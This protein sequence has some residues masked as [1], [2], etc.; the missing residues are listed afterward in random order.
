MRSHCIETV[1]ES[2]E[3]TKE[4]SA[5][6]QNCVGEPALQYIGKLRPHFLASDG[7]TRLQ[8]K[9]GWFELFHK[10]GVL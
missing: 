2:H 8:A 9:G 4:A 10:S 5:R 3:S 7:P 6:A 1:P